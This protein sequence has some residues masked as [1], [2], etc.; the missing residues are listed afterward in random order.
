MVEKLPTSVEDISFVIE[1]YSSEINN[2]W[3]VSAGKTEILCY[4]NLQSTSVGIWKE[5]SYIYLI[6]SQNLL[7]NQQ[8][9]NWAAFAFYGIDK[10]KFL[11]YQSNLSWLIFYLYK[12]FRN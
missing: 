10:I 11:F 4:P 2:F 12:G 3:I 7:Y 6:L 5:L 1:H 8:M 9:I